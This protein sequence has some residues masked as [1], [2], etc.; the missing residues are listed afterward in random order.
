MA[1]SPV[2]GSG[3]HQLRPQQAGLRLCAVKGSVWGH[4]GPAVGQDWQS[5]QVPARLLSAGASVAPIGSLALGIA[6]TLVCVILFPS[7]QGRSHFRVVTSLLVLPAAGCVGA[8]APLEGP[9]L[10][11]SAREHGLVLVL[12]S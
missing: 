5:D 12:A 4:C 6:G 3:L 7:P 11:E 9:L 2:G 8:G 1:F 10:S